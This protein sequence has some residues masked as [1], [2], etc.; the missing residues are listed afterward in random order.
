MYKNRLSGEFPVGSNVGF[1]VPIEACLK[2]QGQYN[3]YRVNNSSG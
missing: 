3:P 1:T 2:V